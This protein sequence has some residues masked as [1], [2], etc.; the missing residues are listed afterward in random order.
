MSTYN[1][2]FREKKSINTFGLKKA[3][4]LEIW[5]WRNKKNTT[6]CG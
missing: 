6:L 4:E 2:C 5:L 3:P 1:I